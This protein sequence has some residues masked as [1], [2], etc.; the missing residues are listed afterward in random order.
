MRWPAKTC[1]QAR[2]P[3]SGGADGIEDDGICSE[4]VVAMLASGQ[5][6]EAHASTCS[7]TKNAAV[8]QN[9]EDMFDAITNG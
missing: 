9:A 8:L 3:P 6:F 7:I 5:R 2:K 1:D 4:E